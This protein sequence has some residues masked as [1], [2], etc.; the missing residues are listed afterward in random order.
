[1]IPEE[2]QMP[3]LSDLDV[4]LKSYLIIHA[5]IGDPGI[6]RKEGLYRRNFV[7]LVDKV[8]KEYQEARD[9]IIAQIEERNRPAEEMIEQGR[10]FYMFGFT[11][12]FENCINVLSRLLRQLDR[13]K[14]EPGS[15]KIDRRV[16][17]IIN[18]HSKAIHCI[19]NSVEHMEND[20]KDDKLQ[21]GQPVML[22]IGGNGDRAVLA[23]YEIKFVDVASAIRRLHQIALYL[24]KDK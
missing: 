10:I 20:I 6:T 15:W 12:H 9:S 1:M 24:F 2:C 5:L 3:D 21:D 18:A 16:R 14:S 19:R 23:E 7:R 11:N 17:H 8:V 13:I 22:S 4:S